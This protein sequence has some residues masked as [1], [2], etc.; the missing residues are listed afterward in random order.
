MTT[1]EYGSDGRG[2]LG[3]GI[4]DLKAAKRYLRRKWN[5]GPPEPVIRRPGCRFYVTAKCGGKAYALLGPYVSHMTALVA[6][7]R[8]QR[9]LDRA[10]V[11]D[12]DVDTSFAEMTPF[13]RLRPFTAVGTASAPV[14]VPTVFGR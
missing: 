3:T 11:G 14:T 7:V 4:R 9:L 8:A 5:Q 6:V 13:A 2:Y 1:S 10:Q 12:P